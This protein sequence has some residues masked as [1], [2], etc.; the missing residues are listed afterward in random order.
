MSKA[1]EFIFKNRTTHGCGFLD[2][3]TE[4]GS[5]N[6]LYKLFSSTDI[7]ACIFEDSTRQWSGSDGIYKLV[8]KSN[9]IHYDIIEKFCLKNHGVFYRH[10]VYEYEA[11]IISAANT[12]FAMSSKWLTLDELLELSELSEVSGDISKAILFNLK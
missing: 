11:S 2:R 4:L 9:H 3:Y 5:Q 1:T 6:Y 10:L 8:I 12:I 7:G